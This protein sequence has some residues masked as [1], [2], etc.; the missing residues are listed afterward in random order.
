MSVEAIGIESRW[1]P[2]DLDQMSEPLE[3]VWILATTARIRC[4]PLHWTAPTGTIPTPR[5]LVPPAFRTGS[6][7]PASANWLQS[8]RGDV[9]G[10]FCQEVES[11]QHVKVFL[12]VLGVGRVKED[13]PL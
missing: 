12:E 1:G 5:H 10:E 11:I 9:L 7:Q 2:P 13:P 6:V 8:L 4:G 3:F